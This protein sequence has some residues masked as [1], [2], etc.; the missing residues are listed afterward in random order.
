MICPIFKRGSSFD[1]GNCR[2]IHLTAILSKIAERVIGRDLLNFLQAKAF[3]PFQWAFTPGL[4]A[5]DLVTALFMTWILAACH[6]K[7]T[8]GYLGDISGAFDRVCK[9]YLMAKLHQAGVGATYLN[10]LDSYLQPRSAAV[11]VEGTR[12]DETEIADTVFQGTV[13]GPSL[14]NTFF[15][16]V[17]SVAIDSNAKP[18]MFADDLNIFKEFDRLMPDTIVSREM[19]VCRARVHSWGRTNRVL[20][21]PS[22]EHVIAIHPTNGFGDSFKLLGCIVDCKLIMK[23]AIDNILPQVRPKMHAILRTKYI[24]TTKELINQFKTHIWGIMEIH[25][26]AIFHAAKYLLDRIDAVQRHFLNE[27]GTSESEA[28]LESNFAPPCLCRDIGILG[29]LHKRA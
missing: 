14:W 29:L 28:F 1:A 18:N 6:G 27:L 21:D 2:G 22:K 17:S 16:N 23:E 19:E 15:S 13:F 24:F 3:G 12:S 26:G 11:V 9:A 7:K 25:N 20:F 10:F 4:S 5:R 8:A